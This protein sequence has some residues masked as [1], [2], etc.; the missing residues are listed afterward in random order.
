MRVVGRHNLYAQ[1]LGEFEDALVDNLLLAVHIV[2]LFVRLGRDALDL[3]LVQHYLKV[4]VVSEQV[5]MPLSGLAGPFVVPGH[6][7]F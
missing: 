3:G 4:I 2:N 5:F 7:V 6:K 1:L